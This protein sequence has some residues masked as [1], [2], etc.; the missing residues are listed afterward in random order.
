[1]PNI[2]ALSGCFIYELER[3]SFS[4]LCLRSSPI[5]CDTHTQRQTE[6]ERDAEG[7]ESE[8]RLMGNPSS[9]VPERKSVVEYNEFRELLPGL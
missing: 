8:I 2:L 3:D 7:W 4:Y 6:E 5:S 9:W 1:M